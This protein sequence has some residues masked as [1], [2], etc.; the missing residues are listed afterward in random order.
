MSEFHKKISKFKSVNS[1]TEANK[2][3]KAKVLDNAGDLFNE[4]YYIYKEKYEEEKDALN[5]RGSKKFDHTKLRLSDD[6]EYESEEEEE[7]TD[8]NLLKN[9]H[10]KN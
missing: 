4:L 10:P 3:L 5:E 8:K 6:Y 2:D 9:L 1:Q 7:Q